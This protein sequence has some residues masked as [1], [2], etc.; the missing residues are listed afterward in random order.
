MGGI[1][2]GMN[3]AV[4][5]LVIIIVYVIALMSYCEGQIFQTDIN[6]LEDYDSKLMDARTVAFISLVWSENVRSYVSRSFD[7]P[8]WINI[9]GNKAMQK[10]IILAQV[11][12]YVAVLLP[13]FSD[14][15]LGLR[16]VAVGINGWLLALIGPVGCVVLCEI[17]K[18]I[19]KMQKQAYQQ[20]TALRRKAKEEEDRS[21][22][23][24][25]QHSQAPTKVKSSAKMAVA[26]EGDAPPARPPAKKVL[27]QNKKGVAQ[28]LPIC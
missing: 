21:S 7:Q 17:C 9:W 2:M 23:V 3:G 4:L 16:G 24:V 5:S 1:G 10:A 11:A 12:L 28:C 25:R 14:M 22:R 27:Q 20:E 13:G 26:H 15:I 18:L 6:K 8:V 19:T